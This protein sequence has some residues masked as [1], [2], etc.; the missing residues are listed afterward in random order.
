MT[1]WRKVFGYEKHTYVQSFPVTS[2]LLAGVS[3]YKDTIKGINIGD[4]LDMS[5]EPN[6][7]DSSAIIIKKLK[8][9]CGYV[10][11]DFY[12]PLYLG[13]IRNTNTY[14]N[15]IEYNINNFEYYFL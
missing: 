5:F 15:C 11:I 12:A 13:S 6:K 14:N 8:D 3:F 1:D 10:P 2:F 4:I 9:I 7:Y